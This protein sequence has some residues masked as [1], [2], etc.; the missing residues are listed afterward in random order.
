MY[1]TS[2]SLARSP[3]LGAFAAASMAPPSSATCASPETTRVRELT[4]DFFLLDSEA[5]RLLNMEPLSCVTRR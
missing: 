2:S 5:I 4:T 1:V 3:G